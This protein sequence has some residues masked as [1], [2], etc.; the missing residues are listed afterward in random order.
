MERLVAIL[1]PDLTV[2]TPDGAALRRSLELLDALGALCPFTEIVRLGLYVLPA[3]APSRVFGG[4]SAVLEALA[5]T[6]REVVGA[7]ARIG[8]ADGLFAAEAAARA[9]RVVAPGGSDD[10]RRALPLAALGRPDLTATAHRLGLRTVGA[11]AD[12]APGRVAERF[13]RA[14]GVAHRV[15]RGE[16]GELPGQRDAS[17]ARRLARLRE[18]DRPDEQRGFFGQRAAG[19]ARARAAALALRRRLGP[20]GVVVAAVV[21]GR[22]PEDRGS[23]RPWDAPPPPRDPGAPWPGQLRPP[24]PVTVLGRP[25]PIELR[26]GEGGSL[27]VRRG[28]LSA[29]PATIVTGGI[30]RR[31][32]WHAGPWPSVERWWVAPRRRAH[33]QLVLEGGEALLV[34]VES[35]RWWLVGVYD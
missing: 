31:V 27:E 13:S 18:V 29:A 11:F 30:T 33:V 20:E 9:G 24:T 26:D 32:V 16:L 34:R 4:E 17:L 28:L 21:G 12:L 19:E 3:R 5:T 7:E 22:T 6:V 10:F 23:L 2:E 15:A 25:A 35:G 14:V 8:V 1:V